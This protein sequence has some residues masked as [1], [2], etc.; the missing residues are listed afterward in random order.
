[1]MR[2]GDKDHTWEVLENGLMYVYFPSHYERPDTRR[3]DLEDP[4][5]WDMY[6]GSPNTRTRFPEPPSLSI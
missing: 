2:D 1:M 5:F 6:H 4:S 3:Y